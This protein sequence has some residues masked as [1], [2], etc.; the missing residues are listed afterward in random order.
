MSIISKF[1]YITLISFQTYILVEGPHLVVASSEYLQSL[2]LNK[3]KN[4]VYSIKNAVSGDQ[5]CSLNINQ[6]VRGH[7]LLG[8]RLEGKHFKSKTPGLCASTW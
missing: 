3:M 7:R 8:V 6:C 4:K 2:P 1:Y 5:K